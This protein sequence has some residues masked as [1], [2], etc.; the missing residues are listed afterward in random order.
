MPRRQ[1]FTALC[2]QAAVSSPSLG[3][4][5]L[6]IHTTASD[7]KYSPHE[8]VDLA[9]RSGLR[10]IAITDHDTVLG[11]R[12]A[13][14]VSSLGL[15]VLSGVELVA[16]HGSRQFHVLGYFIDVDDSDLI[17]YLA[18]RRRARIYRFLEM[19]ERLAK[20]GVHVERPACD[21][22]SVWGRVHLAR[23]IVQAGRAQSEREAFARYLHDQAPATAPLPRAPF[24]SVI[25]I[26][27]A[28]G[29]V[30]ALAH[31]PSSITPREL[32]E[33]Q[34]LGLAAVE[35][36][37]PGCRASRRMQLKEWA[38]ELGLA[39]TGGSDCHGP[40]PARRAVGSRGIDKGE[41]ERLRIAA[42]DLSSKSRCR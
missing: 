27:R 36:D 35:I 31:P 16:D 29:G 15:E 4:A 22:A 32:G 7:G 11:V 37:F 30:L 17:V 23:L 5:D 24:D 40:E 28:A 14:A 3:R 34:T 25:K 13:R 18:E 10:A 33:L 20:Q 9:A 1:P 41:L 21:P 19:L 26:I 38:E 12:A 6:H 42:M 2:R 39:V 8:V